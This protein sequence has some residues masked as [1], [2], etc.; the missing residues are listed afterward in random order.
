[1][2]T[3]YASLGWYAVAAQQQESAYRIRV[4]QLAGDGP[5]PLNWLAVYYYWAGM[6]REAEPLYQQVLEK[7]LERD[8]EYPIHKEHL[9]LVWNANLGVTRGALG[10]FEEAELLVR[11]LVEESP[12]PGYG[13]CLGRIYRELGRHEA[14]ERVLRESLNAGRKRDEED[15][16]WRFVASMVR[17]MHELGLLRLAQG[18]DEEAERLFA[19]GIEYGSREL[20]GKDHPHTLRNMHGLA[21]IRIKQERY[22]EADRLLERV[23]TGQELKLGKDHPRRLQT[24]NDFGVLRREQQHYDEAESLF[25]QALEG[26]QLKLGDDHP[27]TLESKYDLAVL[28][29][30]KDNYAK[31][32]PLLLEVIEGRRLK[33]GD[34][35]PH[36]KESLNNL[37]ALYQAWGKPEKAEQWK[38]KLSE[39]RSRP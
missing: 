5:V 35:H 36:T 6:Y 37:I 27:D 20:P 30:E 10:R 4:D 32:E 1:M 13:L 24:I 19:E 21:T 34:T 29:K 38:V 39:S 33:L 16:S 3:I 26:R 12:G 14:A 31:A 7:C 28:Y 9:W 15:R 25:H 8:A 17:C 18:D 2:A 23:L 22:E 11:P